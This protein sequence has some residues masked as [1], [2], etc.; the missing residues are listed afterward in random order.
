M[1]FALIGALIFCGAGA[2]RAAEDHA[3][4][5][6]DLNPVQA[7]GRRLYQQSCGVCHTKPTI[8]SPLFGPQLSKA[9]V[10]GDRAAQARKQIADGSPNMPGFK[11][12]YK[13]EQIDAVVE[14][15]KLLPPPAAAPARPAGEAAPRNPSTA[16]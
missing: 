5:P 10:D 8:T 7:E 11:Y 15:L 13:P 6:A 3:H 4:G 14:F 9:V 16:R 12:L 1:R 2:V